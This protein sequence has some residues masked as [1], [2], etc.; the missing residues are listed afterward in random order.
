M[1]SL[2]F[3]TET[4]DLIKNKLAPLD[5]QPYVI[6]FFA[7]ALDIEGNE[8]ASHHFLFDPGIP[9]SEEVTRITGIKSEDVKGKPRFA[10][11]A[12]EIKKIIEKHDEVVAHNLSYDK[13]VIDFEMRRCG[14][15]V[16][17]P[18][19]TCTVEATEHLKGFRLNLNALHEHLFGEG[20]ENAHRAETDVRALADCFR[21][22]RY[23]G[24]I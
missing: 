5:R 12:E 6:E 14:L 9:I 3:D 1:I 10:S 15:E 19:L 20:F 7:V 22:L 24:M 8:L 11:A 16:E 17:W 2:V 21:E 18:I 13:T 23:S 4:T